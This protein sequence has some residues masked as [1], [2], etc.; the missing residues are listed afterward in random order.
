MSQFPKGHTVL[1]NGL[2]AVIMLV[3]GD[4]H[5]DGWELEVDDYFVRVLCQPDGRPGA[6]ATRVDAKHLRPAT[7]ERTSE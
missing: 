6:W 2:P 5:P 1:M 4:F 3:P 7:F